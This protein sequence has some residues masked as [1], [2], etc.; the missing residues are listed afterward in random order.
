M[1]DGLISLVLWLS[2]GGAG[3][4]LGLVAVQFTKR[5]MRASAPAPVRMS[6]EAAVR[7]R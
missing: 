3:M 2:T 7:V 1:H 6:N 5:R 4:A